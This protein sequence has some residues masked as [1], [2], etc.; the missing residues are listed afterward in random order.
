MKPNDILFLIKM[1]HDG[2]WMFDKVVEPDLGI[3]DNFTTKY[4]Q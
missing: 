4:I 2:C 1:R 3:E